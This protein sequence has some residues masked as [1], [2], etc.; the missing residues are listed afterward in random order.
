TIIGREMFVTSLRGFLEQHGM[1]F[2][3]T[4]SGKL[5]MVLQCAAVTASLL[6]LSPE[7]VEL[8]PWCI[9]VRDILLWSAVA[10]T[11]YSGLIYIY[12]AGVMIRQQSAG[13]SD[14]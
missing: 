8:A 4:L 6:S 5:K 7:F 11:L 13:S 14:S 9:S 12:R 10:I 3:A 1:D 2:S